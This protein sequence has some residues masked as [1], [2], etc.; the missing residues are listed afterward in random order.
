MD[1][2]TE[3]AVGRIKE[4]STWFKGRKAGESSV[5][6]CLDHMAAELKNWSDSVKRAPFS[7]HPHAFAL[8]LP[9][10]GAFDIL[11]VISLWIAF[12]SGSPV[13]RALDPVFFFSAFLTLVFEFALYRRPLD[14]LLPKRHSFNVFAVRRAKAEPRRRVILCAHA[15]SAYEMPML[16]RLSPRLSCLIIFTAGLGMTA[17]LIAGVLNAAGVFGE[18]TPLALAIVQTAF[19][20]SFIPFLFFVD[21]KT[22]VDGANDDLS[23]CLIAMGIMKEMHENSVRL[24]HTDVCCL[25]TDGE[26]CGLRGAMA[27]A[28]KHRDELE[29][30]VVVAIDTIHDENEIRIYHRGINFTQRNSAKVCGLIRRAG[31]E[32]GVDIPNTGF[33]PGAT[34][35]DAFS[36]CG[37]PAA[38]ICAV[39]HRPSTFYHNRRDT[40]ENLS[41]ECMEL[42]GKIV[43]RLLKIIDEE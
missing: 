34:D 8:S 28:E 38:A 3:W 15:D 35:A 36:R 16:C 30:A 6:N 23:G 43:R 25:I 22:V 26:E 11:A 17:L 37:I 42:T 31:L 1:R 4:I 7:F 19:L 24:A 5:K 39:P 13:F 29:K 12:F 32:C 10:M 21:W 33:Y 18:R 20:P 9:L 2:C 41:P 14:R 40:W 27:F